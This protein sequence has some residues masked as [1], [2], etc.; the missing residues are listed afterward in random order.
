MSAPRVLV[1]TVPFGD[2]DRTPLDLL[3]AAGIGYVINPLG[4]KLRPDEVVGLLR[5]FEVVIAGTE[6]ITDTVLAAA[7]RL[8]LIARVGVGLDSVDLLS[9][10][11]R[12]VAV[13]YTPEAPA[14]A[15][16]ELTVGLIIACLRDVLGA[17]R[18]IRGGEWNRTMGRRI[19]DVTVGLVGMGRIGKRVAHLLRAFGGRVIACDVAFDSAFGDSYG[20]EPVT[21]EALLRGADVI[22]VHVPLSP[23]THDLIGEREFEL[24]RPSAVLVNTARGGIVNEN[25]LATALQHG[26]LAAAA[27]DVFVDEPYSGRLRDCERCILTAHM[28]SMSRD[29]RT[30]MEIEATQDAIR[31]LRGEPVLQLVPPEEYAERRRALGR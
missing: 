22:S 13:A 4:R 10:E 11:R 15:V 30:R 2:I 14:P 12:G 1:T 18:R 5:D 26:R 29:C 27:I 19:A 9:A 16:A 6:P 21:L 23:S 3:D 20:V 17:D 25:A 7:P 28:G 8:G 24:M 31:F